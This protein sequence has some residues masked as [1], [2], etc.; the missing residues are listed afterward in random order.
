[1]L[2]NC[3]IIYLPEKGS[4]PAMLKFIFP[5]TMLSHAQF[6]FSILEP[7]ILPYTTLH[8]S[9]GTNNNMKKGYYWYHIITSPHITA[10]F[11]IWY[12][13]KKSCIFKSFTPEFF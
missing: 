7:I 1:M 9:K 13:K 11:S 3:N 4:R 2:G 6:L 8:L 5:F 12:E 10:L